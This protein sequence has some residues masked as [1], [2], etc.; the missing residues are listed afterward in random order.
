MSKRCLPVGVSDE[1]VTGR[2][3]EREIFEFGDGGGEETSS[4]EEGSREWSVGWAS[5]DCEVGRRDRGQ[6]AL[7]AAV[8]GT[9]LPEPRS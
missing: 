8:L 2:I 4:R 5:G 1:P 9:L 6:K 3:D 7:P